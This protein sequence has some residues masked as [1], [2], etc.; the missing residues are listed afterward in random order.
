MNQNFKIGLF[1]KDFQF[2]SLESKIEEQYVISL[3]KTCNTE[4]IKSKC[5]PTSQ[6]HG[7]FA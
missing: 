4:K 3:R 6:F 1:T 2:F 7:F 5:F